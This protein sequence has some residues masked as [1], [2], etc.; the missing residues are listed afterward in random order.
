ME[1]KT[2]FETHKTEIIIVGSIFCA[3][4]FGK[5]TGYNEAFRFVSRSLK[6]AAKEVGKTMTV[7]PL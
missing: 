2:F 3:Y 4:L 1:Q 7:T 5:M 6:D